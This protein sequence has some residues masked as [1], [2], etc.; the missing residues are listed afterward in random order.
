MTEP[1]AMNLNLYE[2]T[3]IL[4]S[5]LDEA[6]QEAKMAKVQEILGAAGGHVEQVDKWGRR[7]LAYEIKGRRDGIYLFVRFRAPA[8]ALPELDRIL[9]L[10][11]GIL[12]HLV[13][14]GE[15]VPVVETIEATA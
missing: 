6:T 14:V 5:T 1:S 2:L 12:R 4:A 7:G 10:D 8:K 3:L 9:K 11:E 13:V 15:E